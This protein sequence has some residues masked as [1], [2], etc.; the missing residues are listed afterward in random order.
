M[1]QKIIE[2][3]TQGRG[4]YAITDIITKDLTLPKT[5]LINIFIQHTSASLL[6][7]ENYDPTAKADI[8]E[9]FCRLVP[10]KDKWY[11]HTLEGPDDSTSHLKSAVTATSLNIPITNGKIAL[12]QW[13]GVYLFE[14]RLKPH[15]RKV[16][17]T[18][19]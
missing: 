8:E 12:G 5:G 11:T 15:L 14:H 2:I 19:N 1:Q 13:Q 16:I 3:S 9:F 4:L 10:D 18:L 6:I 7:Q 17:V